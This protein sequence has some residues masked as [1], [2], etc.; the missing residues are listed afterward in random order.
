MSCKRILK[1][2]CLI[3]LMVSGWRSLMDEELGVVERREV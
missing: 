1:L 2:S 3:L